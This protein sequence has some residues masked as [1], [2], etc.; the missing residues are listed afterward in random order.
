MSPIH[1]KVPVA[2]SSGAQWALVWGKV[3]AHPPQSEQR[4]SAFLKRGRRLEMKRYREA[5][6]NSRGR[7]L[8]AVLEAAAEVLLHRRSALRA[9]PWG[10]RS[11]GRLRDR[12]CRSTQRHNPTEHHDTEAN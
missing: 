10:L 12:S 3:G 6:A 7:A 9:G 8:L 4:K 11:E 5:V 1:R 2:F